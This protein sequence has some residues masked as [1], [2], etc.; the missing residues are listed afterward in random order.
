MVGPP[1]FFAGLRI[2]VKSVS[3]TPAV[4]EIWG[5]ELLERAILGE[6]DQR[7]SKV[8]AL[9]AKGKAEKGERELWIVSSLAPV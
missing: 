7:T 8:S 9:L 6:D 2:L 3:S 4:P 5:R 1:P